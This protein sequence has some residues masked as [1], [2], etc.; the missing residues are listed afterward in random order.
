MMHRWGWL[1]LALPV[2]LAVPAARADVTFQ[3]PAPDSIQQTTIPHSVNCAYSAESDGVAFGGYN[4][5]GLVGLPFVGAQVSEV[6]G[7]WSLYCSYSNGASGNVMSVGPDPVIETCHFGG[8]GQTCKGSLAQCAFTCASKPT[9]SSRAEPR[10]EGAVTD[11]ARGTFE[12]KV[13]PLGGEEGPEGEGTAGLGRMSLD[14]VFHGDLEG[15]SV[16][17]M[18]TVGTPT[19]GSAAYVALETVTGALAGRKGSFVLLH[20]GTINRGEQSLS[21]TAVPGSGT[22]ELAGIAGGMTIEIHDGEHSYD[23]EYTLG[24]S[25]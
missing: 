1:S 23:L 13:A 19:E 14:K 6:N 22:G 24:E 16:G 12:V 7:Y 11:H 5:C 3:C 20:G 9:A 18:L 15:T 21:I 8:G 10:K 25:P 17:Q 2:L 4:N